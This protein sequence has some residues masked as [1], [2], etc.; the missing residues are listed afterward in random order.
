MGDIGLWVELGKVARL[1]GFL[2]GRLGEWNQI[3]G[4][5][6]SPPSC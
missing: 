4:I 2:H 5:V 1:S 3:S 6:S